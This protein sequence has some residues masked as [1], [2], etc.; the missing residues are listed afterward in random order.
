MDLCHLKNAELAKHL[1][2]YKR[3]PVLR[4]D[5]V[6]DEGWYRA[7][8]TEHGASASQMAAATFL[9]AMTK[10]LGMAG[11]TSDA[12]SAY[13]RVTMTE[14]PR[15]LRM[16]KE[17]CPEMWIRIPPRQIPTGGDNI[18]DQS[19][20][21]W[22]KLMWSPTGRPCLGKKMWRSDFRKRMGGKYQLGECLHVHKK[23]GFFSLVYVD[24]IKMVGKEQHNGPM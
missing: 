12:I 10:L 3:Q 5:N 1:Q 11:E 15:L 17:E 14:A 4:C 2:E 20:T 7:V 8:F 22:K 18:E 13:T 24:D 9:D 16:P 19:G 23:L 6:K 21:C